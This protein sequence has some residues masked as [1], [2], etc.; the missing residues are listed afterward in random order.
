[1]QM[2][3]KNLVELEGPFKKP[4]CIELGNKCQKIINRST[5]KWFNSRNQPYAG[6]RV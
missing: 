5:E 6:G 1:M 4:T 2:I 3:E